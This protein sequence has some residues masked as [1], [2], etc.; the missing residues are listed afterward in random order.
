M[1]ASVNQIA[2]LPCRAS[3][4]PPPVVSWRKDGAPLDPESPRWVLVGQVLESSVDSRQGHPGQMER[5]CE[6]VV[7]I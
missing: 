3:G 5:K 7:Y 1:N 6:F 4:E 2:L